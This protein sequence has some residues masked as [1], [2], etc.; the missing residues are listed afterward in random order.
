MSREFKAGDLVRFRDQK[1]KVVEINFFEKYP[2]KVRFDVTG[3]SRFTLDGRILENQDI[4][5]FHQQ[6]QQKSNIDSNIDSNIGN[7]GNTEG[8]RF[9]DGKIEL[10]QCPEAAIYAIAS[11][12]MANSEKHGGK[13]PDQNWRKGMD[14]SKVINCALRHL[15]KFNGG[16]D[17][18]SESGKPHLWHALCNLAMLAEYQ[19]THPEKDDRYKNNVLKDMIDFDRAITK[20]ES[21]NE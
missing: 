10:T 14:W 1:G 15:Y 5:L 2:I 6:P 4:E 12:L 13:Y 8:L 21:S 9:N 7:I 11:V 17:L 19:F 20:K 3:H 18:D 16:E